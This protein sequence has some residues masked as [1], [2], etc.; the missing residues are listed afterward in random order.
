MDPSRRTNS[1]DDYDPCS[2]MNTL[3]PWEKGNIAQV[4]YLDATS[5][6]LSN[7]EREALPSLWAVQTNNK[8]AS[9]PR[10]ETH[11]RYVSSSSQRN[12]YS[13]EYSNPWGVK[14]PLTAPPPPRPVNTP[15][16]IPPAPKS[17]PCPP[18]WVKPPP[19]PPDSDFGSCTTTSSTGSPHSKQGVNPLPTITANVESDR[20]SRKRAP[21]STQESRKRGNR[22]QRW[23]L[24]LKEM[25]THQPV[26]ESEFEHISAQGHWTDE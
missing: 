7:A 4:P 13:D 26:D 2:G 11:T 22:L 19:T 25:F 18:S 9:R 12:G 3:P 15:V 16:H 10:I 21:T 17:T 20:P 6:S 14:T 8:V 5:A 24:A 23:K 1:N